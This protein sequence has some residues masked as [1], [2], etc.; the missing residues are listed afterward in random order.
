MSK[1]EKNPVGRPRKAQADKIGAE[2]VRLPLPT[3]G[4][5]AIAAALE[6]G[7]SMS[8]FIRTAIEREIERRRKP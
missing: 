8:S 2:Q 5:A 3:G 7:E 6:P 1:A 4:K